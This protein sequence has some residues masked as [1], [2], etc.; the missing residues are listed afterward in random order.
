MY[1]IS[2]DRQ[3]KFVHRHYNIKKC[4]S[5][6]YGVLEPWTGQKWPKFAIF[7]QC[8]YKKSLKKIGDGS[9][10]PRKVE[11]PRDFTSTRLYNIIWGAPK[12]N[13]GQKGFT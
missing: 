13:F 5:N 6:H 9:E 7:G 1:S 8:F 10:Y 3:K 4:F 12:A 2:L 11:E